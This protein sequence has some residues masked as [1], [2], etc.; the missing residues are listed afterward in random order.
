MLLN[1]LRLY[2]RSKYIKRLGIFPQHARSNEFTGIPMEALLDGFIL[3][4]L[5]GDTS[6]GNN[7][8]EHIY[9]GVYL[10]SGVLMNGCRD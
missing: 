4:L 6:E 9:M 7:Y 10:S 1:K 3:E 5:T 8:R 2:I